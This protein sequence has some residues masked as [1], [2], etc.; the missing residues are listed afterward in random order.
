MSDSMERFWS[1]LVYAAQAA[2]E[3]GFFPASDLHE[4]DRHYLLSM[5]IPGVKKENI[6]IEFSNHV[7]HISGEKT[8]A[9][10]K[11]LKGKA[12]FF[13][14]SGGKFE[15][16]FQLP[17]PVKADN[18]ETCFKDGVLEVLLPKQVHKSHKIPIGE[19]KTES[20]F[21]R[22]KGSTKH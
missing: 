19:G 16:H 11:N 20:L 4:T 3:T 5:E 21:A 7:L 17:E 8:H 1:P 18:I 14:R 9:Y 12:E 10:K 15:R 6:H 22:L 2:R 13:E